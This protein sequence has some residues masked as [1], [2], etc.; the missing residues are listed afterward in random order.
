MK[1]LLVK[2][3]RTLRIFVELLGKVLK[4]WTKSKEILMKSCKWGNL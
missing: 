2:F 3:K 1:N 4:F